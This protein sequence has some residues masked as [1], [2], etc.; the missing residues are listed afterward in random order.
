[1]DFSTP[2]VDVSLCSYQLGEL[3]SFPAVYTEFGGIR[4]TDRPNGAS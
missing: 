4:D 2:D 3:L 1:M